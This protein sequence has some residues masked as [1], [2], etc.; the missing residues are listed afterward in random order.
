[1]MGKEE[2]EVSKKIKKLVDFNSKRPEQMKFDR[3]HNFPQTGDDSLNHIMYAEQAFAHGV[4]PSAETLSFLIKA[5][6]K[7]LDHGKGSGNRYKETKIS[8]NIKSPTMD[9]CLGLKNSARKYFKKNSDNLLLLEM[10]FLIIDRGYPIAKAAEIIARKQHPK[11]PKDEFDPFCNTLIS[12][13][14][15]HQGQKT[16]ALSRISKPNRK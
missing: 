4:L 2:W 6:S 8:K 10:S 1:M 7:Y 12:N 16:K 15:K 13:Y 11:M 5:F 14:N 3:E 9:E